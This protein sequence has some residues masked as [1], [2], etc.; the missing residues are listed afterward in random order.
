MWTNKSKE[1]VGK[2]FKEAKLIKFLNPFDSEQINFESIWVWSRYHV[3]WHPHVQASCVTDT[4]T[5]N[6]ANRRVALPSLIIRDA[7]L[8][9]LLART[10]FA[11]GCLLTIISQITPARHLARTA[12]AGLSWPSLVRGYPPQSPSERM[13][14]FLDHQLRRRLLC[15]GCPRTNDG[16]EDTRACK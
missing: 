7:S 8:Y 3:Q 13:F 15:G 9:R 11:C 4:R 16:H 1:S 10:A 6:I 14:I 12:R 5:S 2:G